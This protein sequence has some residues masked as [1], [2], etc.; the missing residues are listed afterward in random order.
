MG[1]LRRFIKSELEEIAREG[2]KLRVIGDYRKLEPDVVAL[3]DD[4]VARTASNTRLT[5]AI[6]LNYGSQGRAPAG[7]PE[8]DARSTGRGDRSRFAR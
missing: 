6:A 8:V 7:D 5:L 3:L 2:V 1:L 4:A